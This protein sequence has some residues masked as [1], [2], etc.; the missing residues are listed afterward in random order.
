MKQAPVDAP[1]AAGRVK[2]TPA[3]SH[4]ND[5]QGLR[6]VAVLTVL[7][8]HTGLGPEGGFIGVDV[9]FVLSGFLITGLL[10]REHDRNGRISLPQFWSRRAKRLLPASSLVLVVTLI[11]TRFYLPAGR[12][13]SIGSDAIAASA[14]V[15]NWRL[16]AESVDYLA[17]GAAASP[18]QHYWSLSIEEQFYVVWPLL[19]SLVLLARTRKVAIAV[20][21]L[22][23]AGSFALALATYDAQTYFTTQTRVWELAAGALAA[24]VMASSRHQRF[25]ANP[26]RWT[27][28]LSWV[29]LA[30][31][32]ALLFVVKPAT[33]WPG[34]MTGLVV[35]CTLLVLGFGAHPNSAGAVLSLKPMTWLGD[36]S[37]SL[38]L[39]HWPLVIFAER[40][41]VL[42]T[43]EGWYIVAAGI[44]LA[45]AT[46]FLV[47]Q[48]RPQGQVPGPGQVRHR[49]R[50][51]PGARRRGHRSRAHRGP[52]GE[53][54][55]E[56][57]GSR[58][59]DQAAEGRQR[60]GPP[61][62]GGRGRQ[63]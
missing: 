44:A 55:G 39:W 29:G 16:A 9:F 1:P 20:I 51:D 4:R 33:M 12:W 36:I 38:Y 22:V 8:Y 24:V 42:T 25:A 35:V 46:Y 37:Y 57:P 14:Y 62:G 54:P 31:I 3:S 10:V 11:V 21:A 63:R 26:P 43:A 49:H 41:G 53:R 6:A 52:L 28:L 18:L 13:D 30:G 58:R 32:L 50:P 40:D 7:L 15:V 2:T 27:G 23:T 60:A 45:T 47:E 48:P 19:M 5:I 61:P 34:P 59:H 17:E 56:R